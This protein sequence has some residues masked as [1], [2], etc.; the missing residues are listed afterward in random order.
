[1]IAS[2]PAGITLGFRRKFSP[3]PSGS[4]LRACSVSHRSAYGSGTL[5]KI[6]SGKM[7]CFNLASIA[8]RA[9][10]NNG[11][12]PR[13]GILS[14][15]EIDEDTVLLVWLLGEFVGGVRVAFWKD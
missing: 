13:T 12:S 1:M 7:I 4:C 5:S 9:G 6:T 8:S 14:R 2:G 3:V 11:K 15:G 10:P